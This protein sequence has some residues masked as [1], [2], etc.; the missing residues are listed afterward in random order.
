MQRRLRHRHCPQG[1][2]SLVGGSAL[3]WNVN[4]VSCS[5]RPTFCNRMDCRPPGSSVEFSRQEYW[6]GLPFPYPGD[7]PDPGM[8][9]GSPALQADSLPSVSQFSRSVVSDS[10]WPH[11]PQHARPPCPSSTPGVHPNP[12]PLSWW[13]H[14]AISSSV[15][16]LSSFPHYHQSHHNSLIMTLQENT[17]VIPQTLPTRLE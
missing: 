1:I 16:P 3:W 2:H 17:D 9:P 10:L 15:V 4:S 12:C 5:V 11:E 8:E 7:L 13:C 6:S 14:P